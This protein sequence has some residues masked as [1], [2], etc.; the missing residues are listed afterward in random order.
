MDDWKTIMMKAKKGNRQAIEV[1]VI[2]MTQAAQIIRN[3]ESECGT[4]ALGYAA[5]IEFMM[6]FLRECYKAQFGGLLEKAR[7][8]PSLIEFETGLIP[9]IAGVIES[10]RKHKRRIETEKIERRDDPVMTVI[11][12][13]AMESVDILIGAGKS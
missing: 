3:H 5:G 8:K 10:H 1:L 13:E 4:F 12:R 11:Y 2:K 6:G 9:T 7:T